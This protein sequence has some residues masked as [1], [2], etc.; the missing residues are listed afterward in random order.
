[1][2]RNSNKQ[3]LGYLG[4][5]RFVKFAFHCCRSNHFNYFCLKLT[6]F[7]GLARLDVHLYFRLAGYTSHSKC[8]IPKA[9]IILNHLIY[10]SFPENGVIHAAVLHRYRPY[11]VFSP[12]PLPYQE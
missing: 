3:Y 4:K 2:V 6:Y 10:Q 5:F 9:C 11:S 7:G 1:M 12:D 8:K